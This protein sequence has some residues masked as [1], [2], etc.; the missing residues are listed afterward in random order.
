LELGLPPVQVS[1]QDVPANKVSA[2]E[3]AIREAAR[4]VGQ[5]FLDEGDIG[6]AWPFFRMI[7][8]PAPI[9]A[10]IDRVQLDAGDS[11]RTQQIIQ[12][13]PSP[14]FSVGDVF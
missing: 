3:S 12:I 11:D 7:Q 10:G 9:A 8:D 6:G 14:V 2:Y 5:L 13:A 1:S 4:S